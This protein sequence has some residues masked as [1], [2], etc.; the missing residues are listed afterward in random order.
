MRI[1]ILDAQGGGVGRQLVTAIKGVLPTAE[2]TAVGTNSAASTAMMKAGADHVATGENAVL[3]GCRRA[4]VI[5]GPVGI[6]IAD[7]LW[8]EITPTMACA[9]G[10]SAAKKILI[11]MNCC[12]TLVAGVPETGTGFLIQKAVDELLRLVQNGNS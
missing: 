3:V 4:D 9:V 8:G 11:P 5:L 12:D 7:A 6:V 10:Q 1:L 2:I